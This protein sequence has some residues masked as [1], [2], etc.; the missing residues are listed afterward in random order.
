MS[1]EEQILPLAYKQIFLDYFNTD[2][3]SLQQM[4][5]QLARGKDVT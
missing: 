5:Q 4:L 1:F 2:P 3:V